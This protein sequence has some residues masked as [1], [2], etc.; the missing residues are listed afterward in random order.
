MSFKFVYVDGRA[1]LINTTATEGETGIIDVSSLMHYINV[2]KLSRDASDFSTRMEIL[3]YVMTKMCF[4]EGHIIDNDS[5]YGEVSR[6]AIINL[7]HEKVLHRPKSLVVAMVN[8]R[9]EYVRDKMTPRENPEWTCPGLLLANVIECSELQSNI[10][11]DGE[12][13]LFK[14]N[15]TAAEEIAFLRVNMEERRIECE[16][17]NPKEYFRTSLM[18]PGK[19]KRAMASPGIGAAIDHIAASLSVNNTKPVDISLRDIYGDSNCGISVSINCSNN[20][21]AKFRTLGVSKE[22]DFKTKSDYDKALN[23]VIKDLE[24]AATRFI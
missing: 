22:I 10:N 12:L 11:Q 16:M 14:N 7:G 3:A 13:I 23:T 19:I 17:V 9:S 2:V 18:A 1:S 20:I 15:N 8:R 4:T 5:A 21:E 24:N 6:A